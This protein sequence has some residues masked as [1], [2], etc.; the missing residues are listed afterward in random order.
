VP[1]GIVTQDPLRIR[2]LGVIVCLSVE[3]FSTTTSRH[4]SFHKLSTQFFSQM[5]AINF[6]HLAPAIEVL[7][8]VTI[9]GTRLYA[10]GSEIFTVTAILWC[11][12]FLA[13]LTQKVYEFGYAFGKFYRSYLHFHLKSFVVCV[14]A[15]AIVLGDYF[16]EGCKVVYK[17]RRE[18]L[19]NVNI[20]RETVGSYFVYA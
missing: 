15:L 19:E 10:L 20:F 7:E 12:N 13:N 1:A 16:I 9:W 17:N 3:G 2:L 11:L 4:N 18:I 6:F 8:S 14:I 5:T